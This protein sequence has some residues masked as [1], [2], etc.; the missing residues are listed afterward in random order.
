M[1]AVATSS[2][3]V[4]EKRKDRLNETLGPTQ[5]LPASSEA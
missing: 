3:T 2:I 1:G 4:V 5:I